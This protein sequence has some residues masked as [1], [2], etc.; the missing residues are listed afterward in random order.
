MNVISGIKTNNVI[1]VTFSCLMLVYFVSQVNGLESEEL[2]LHGA[3][4][5]PL[6]RSFGGNA[7]DLRSLQQTTRVPSERCA[8]GL[9]VLLKVSVLNTK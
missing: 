7:G 5:L 3:A 2:T 6:S 9:L 1:S 4:H 8:K